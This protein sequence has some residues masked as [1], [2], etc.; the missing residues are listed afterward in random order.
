MTEQVPPP[1]D[2]PVINCPNPVCGHPI[3]SHHRGGRHLDPSG[4]SCDC[5]WTPNDIAAHLLTWLLA[6][7]PTPKGDTP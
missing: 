2:L 5:N 4:T 6:G 7:E 3:N 1:R